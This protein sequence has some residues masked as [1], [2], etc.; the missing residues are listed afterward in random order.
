M[1]VSNLSIENWVA[2]LDEGNLIESPAWSQIEQAIREL[3]G[4]TKTLVTLGADDE[5]Y[6]CIGGGESGKYIV[7]VTFDNISF[8]NLVDP[9]KADAIA[10][11]VVGGQE[12]D[13]SLKMCVNLENALLAAQT[14]TESGKLENSL[15]WEEEKPLVMLS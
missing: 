10:K 13:Y 7:N 8:H 11:L 4:K 1:F 12:G 9:S 5:C 2:S 15:F 3:D 14:F 6:M